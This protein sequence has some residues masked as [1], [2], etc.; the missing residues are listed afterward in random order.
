M[1][2]EFWVSSG[3][4]LTCRTPE[5]WLAVTDELLAAYL[6]RPELVPPPEAC[7]AEL[8]LHRPLLKA[9][10]RP[11]SPD[12]I[13]A[14]ADPDARENWEAALAFRDRLIASGTI[15]GAYLELVRNGPGATLCCAP[16]NCFF[17]G[18]GSVFRTAQHC[19]PMMRRSK[20]ATLFS[21][22]R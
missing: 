14:L 20:P 4:H 12:E 19:W 9:P 11:V 2:R 16:P 22:R 17:G 5:G 10:R 15:E 3:H 8:R 6:A 7:A 21:I 13:A 18:N 1:S